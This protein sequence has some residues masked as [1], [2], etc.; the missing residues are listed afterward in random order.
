MHGSLPPAD[1]QQ[2]FRLESATRF[3]GTTTLKFFRK[4]ETGDMDDIDIKVN[5][6]LVIKT[7]TYSL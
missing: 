2:D 7:S 1:G 4:R 6:V 5:I 3:N